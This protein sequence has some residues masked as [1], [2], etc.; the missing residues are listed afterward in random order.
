MAY[1]SAVVGALTDIHTEAL[2]EL[3]IRRVEPNGKEYI[4]LKGVAST[5]AGD[6]VTYDEAGLTTRLVTGTPAGP[7]A[8]AL[9]AT[10]ANTYGWYQIWGSGTINVAAGFVDNGL[11]FS[12]VTAGVV[13]DAVVADSQVLGAVG[14]SAVSG[15]QATVQLSY[16]WFGDT[17]G[18]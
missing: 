5:A 12:T 13:D 1:N 6:A 7:V 14:R 10:V 8:V 16:P 2:N 15:G 18:A 11:I 9:A 4:Y 17:N 3:G